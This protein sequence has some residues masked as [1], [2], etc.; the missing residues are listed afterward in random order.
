M[1]DA[2]PAQH[3]ADDSDLVQLK[4]GWE[5]ILADAD[6]QVA[7]LVDGSRLAEAL[8]EQGWTLQQADRGWVLL[9][10]P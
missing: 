10:R 7:L 6:A 2:Y 3:L 8:Q 5:G 9:A 1:A 4:P